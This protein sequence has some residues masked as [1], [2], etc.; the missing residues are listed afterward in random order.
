MNRKRRSF[1]K[2]AYSIIALFLSALFFLSIYAN[3]LAN[4]RFSRLNYVKETA[5]YA[6]EITGEHAEYLT[7]SRLERAWKILRKTVKRP[8]TYEEY[9]LY[10]SIAIAREDFE[11]AEKNLRGCI[12]TSEG[13]TRD[14]AILHLRLGSLYIL[15]EKDDEAIAEL[16]EALRLEPGLA[17]ARYLR[18]GVYDGKGETE[19]ALA[20]YKVYVNSGTA[21]PSIAAALGTRFEEA[22]DPETAVKCYSAAMGSEETASP[23]LYLEKA[24]CEILTGNRTAGTKDLETYFTMTEEDPNGEASALLGACRMEEGAA[25]EAVELFHRALDNGYENKALLLEQSLMCLYVLERYEEA[26]AD[27]KEAV[28]AAES[29]EGGSGQLYFWTGMALLALGEYKEAQEYLLT[30]GEKDPAIEGIH[31]YLGVCFLANEAYDRAEEEFT[32]SIEKSEYK[33]ES[34]FNRAICYIESEEPEPAANDLKA[35]AEDGTDP[36]ITAQ[37]EEILEILQEG[38]TT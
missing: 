38:E 7:E 21:D 4:I 5:R 24:R 36:E 9:D 37:A 32:A 31:Y 3:I 25:E 28:A 19:K 18:G 13:T 34:L 22:G 29:G 20:D 35:A 1:K 2:T 23:L 10:A 17:S 33:Q 12:E 27:G 8:E 26:A 6:A 11:E 15:Q 14:L 30:A 16:D